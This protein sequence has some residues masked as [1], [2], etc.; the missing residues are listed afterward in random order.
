MSVIASTP[1]PAPAP[2]PAAA[3]LPLYR[4]SVAQYQAMIKAGILTDDDPVEL[5]DGWLVL[6]MPKNPP[7]RV[8]TRKV[9]RALEAI[10]PAAWYADSQEPITLPD[11]QPEPDVMVA[12]AA[13]GQD[14]SRHPGPPD[15]ALVV[16]VADTTLDP[17]RGMKK[18]LYA[19]AAI[20]PYWILN[21]VDNVLEVYTDPS[22]PAAQ[23]DYA[24]SRVLGPAEEVPVVLDGREV[25]RIP[26]REL[27]P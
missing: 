15:V 11:S 2:A 8:C 21:L 6:T 9:R 22:G 12:R 3:A 27:L 14:T 7:H 23:P 26:V 17:D 5:L 25:G 10:L 4:L 1:V 24:A 18:R 20:P 16:E 13:L 19:A